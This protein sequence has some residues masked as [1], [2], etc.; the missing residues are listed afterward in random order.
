MRG[1]TQEE[2]D[3]LGRWR[4]GIYLYPEKRPA[5]DRKP[6]PD[7]SVARELFVRGLGEWEW[8]SSSRRQARV[9][10]LGELVLRA[11]ALARST[12]GV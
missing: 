6:Y 11:D 7:S 9:T 12:L 8:V 10:A 2:R 3:T 5:G 4:A 1:L